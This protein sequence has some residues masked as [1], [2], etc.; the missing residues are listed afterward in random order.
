MSQT[1]VVRPL[2]ARGGL[3][4]FER[5]LSAWVAVCMVTGVIASNLLPSAVAGLRSIEFGRG[6]RQGSSSRSL[7]IG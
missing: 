5:Y 1:A 6:S 7:L 2:K 4:I 3:G